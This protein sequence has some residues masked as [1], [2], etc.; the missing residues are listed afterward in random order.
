MACCTCMVWPYLLSASACSLSSVMFPNCAVSPLS[1]G[2]LYMSP[3][4][5]ECY[6]LPA[7]ST[8][9]PHCLCPSHFLRS[10]SHLSSAPCSRGLTHANSI[11]Q[12]SFPIGIQLYLANGKH[13]KEI[14]GQKKGGNSGNTGCWTYTSQMG[15]WRVFLSGEIQLLKRKVLEQLTFEDSLTKKAGFLP[16]H[17]T[18][19]TQVNMPCPCIIHL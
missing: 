7:A 14:R 10:I 15:D 12:A 9:V 5:L 18:V 13:W 3:L 2:P 16:T 8:S 4:R 6:P 17:Y 19:S 1:I 11:F